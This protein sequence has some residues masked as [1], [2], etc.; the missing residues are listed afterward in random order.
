[1]IYFLSINSSDR[2]VE[3]PRSLIFLYVKTIVTLAKIVSVT[4]AF[5]GIIRVASGPLPGR[6]LHAGHK[7]LRNIPKYKHPQNG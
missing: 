5:Y 2:L 1:M 4:G 6:K 7:Q 3:A